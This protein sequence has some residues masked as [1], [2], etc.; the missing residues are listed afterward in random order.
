MLKGGFRFDI[1]A[2]TSECFFQPG[3]VTSPWRLR[4]DGQSYLKAAMS[5]G[6]QGR[7]ISDQKNLEFIWGFPA[8]PHWMIVGSIFR[9]VGVSDLEAGSP[10]F[11]SRHGQLLLRSG[12]K[13]LPAGNF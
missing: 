1:K 3:E 7:I 5:Q 4:Q 6:A 9:W 13:L 10:G 12:Q 8:E 2:M 11:P